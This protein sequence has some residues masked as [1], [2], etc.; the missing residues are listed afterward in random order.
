MEEIGIIAKLVRPYSGYRYVELIRRT[1]CKWLVR[2][3]D[4][5]LEI[6]IYEDEFVLE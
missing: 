4:S 5:G 6:E 1:G 3:I 2:I